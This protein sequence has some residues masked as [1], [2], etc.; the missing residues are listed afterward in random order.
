M[1][2]EKENAARFM[3]AGADLLAEAVRQAAAD[4]PEDVGALQVILKAGG[5]A[6]V[7]VTLSAAGVAWIACDVIE[8]DGTSHSL[9]TL[10]LRRAVLS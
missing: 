6:R 3:A 8:A 2:G 10:E 1:N 4:H 5:T 7:S 9:A